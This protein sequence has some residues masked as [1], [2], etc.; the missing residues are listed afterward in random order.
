MR[1]TDTESSGT[2]HSMELGGDDRG[3]TVDTMFAVLA[4]Q[5]RRYVLSLLRTHDGMVSLA[6]L[7]DEIVIREHGTRLPEIPTNEVRRIYL[8]LYH[9]HVPKLV[10]AGVVLYDQD[11]DL[12]ATTA[13]ASRLYPYL[14]RCDG[15]LG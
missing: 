12:V 9:V 3:G 14:D 6:D 13:V 15:T 8:S 1:E 10:D 4:D 11:R 7:A 5:R 2:D